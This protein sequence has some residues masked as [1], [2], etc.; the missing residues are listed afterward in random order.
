MCGVVGIMRPSRYARE[1]LLFAE[2]IG[3][4]ALLVPMIE[5]EEYLDEGFE[6]FL[7]R[8]FRGDSDY[9]IFTSVNGVEFTLKRVGDVMEFVRALNDHSVVA[10]I[11]PR[12][13]EAL[14][15]V[16]IRVALLPKV[17][18]SSGLLDLF[19]RRASGGCV[20][21]L[22]STHGAPM[23]VDELLARGAEVHE[24]CV[25]TLTRP[26]GE[27]QYGL[28]KKVLEGGVDGLAFT[29]TMMVHN[30]MKTALEIGILE[31]VVERMGE[32]SV[33]AIGTP[34]ARTL[35]GYGVKGI[36][37]PERSLFKDLLM[38]LKESISR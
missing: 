8:V 36:I 23:L 11:G 14:E 25:Y 22:R 20:E 30:F 10:A 12:T 28:L 3:L 18:S 5:V 26:V 27:E 6:G 19:E 17:Y 24:T 38:A 15:R 35:E 31:G 34:T 29:S 2:S 33:G 32:I 37:V 21:I 9:V 1:S 7:G 4:D 16:G 13:A